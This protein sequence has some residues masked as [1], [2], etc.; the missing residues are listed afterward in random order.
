MYIR[1]VLFIYNIL[2]FYIFIYS[3][4]EEKMREIKDRSAPETLSLQEEREDDK[5]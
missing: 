5:K 2:H 4:K 1:Y 3:A